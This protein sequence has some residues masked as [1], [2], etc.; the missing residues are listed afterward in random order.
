M[1]QLRSCQF[2]SHCLLKE[3]ITSAPVSLISLKKNQKNE[4]QKKFKI[5]KNSELRKFRAQKIS[6]LRKFGARKFQ[7]IKNL[8]N[9]KI[10][11]LNK[12]LI[13][14][15]ILKMNPAYIYFKEIN[16]DQDETFTADF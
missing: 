15:Q 3:T 13:E 14:S 9:K 1:L 12:N 7:N 10:F 4:N 11:L 2:M 8:G 5:N 16:I 6:R